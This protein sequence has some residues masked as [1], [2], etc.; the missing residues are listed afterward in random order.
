[1][2]LAL[3]YAPGARALMNNACCLVAWPFPLLNNTP[4]FSGCEKRLERSRKD[5]N[6]ELRHALLL[7]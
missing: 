7:I 1:M 6:E 3:N 4:F 2:K 5:V